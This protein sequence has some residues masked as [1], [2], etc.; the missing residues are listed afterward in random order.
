MF[1]NVVNKAR[2]KDLLDRQAIAITGFDP[3]RMRT[4]HYPLRPIRVYTRSG[5]PEGQLTLRHDFSKSASEYTLDEDAYVIVEVL[6][7]ISMRQEGIIGHFVLPSHF[8]DR[9][10]S[11]VAGRIENPYGQRGEAIRF[12]VKNLLQQPNYLR[13]DD[14]VAYVYF[15]DLLSLKNEDSY[16]PTEQEWNLFRRWQTRKEQIGDSGWPTDDVE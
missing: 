3:S 5:Q 13:K 10:L 6:E 2:L 12:G 15:V 9:G 16:R 8:I 11:L 1:G 14:T 4:I 7:Q